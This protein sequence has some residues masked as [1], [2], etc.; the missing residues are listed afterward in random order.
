[1]AHRDVIHYELLQTTEL[2]L[3]ETHSCDEVVSRNDQDIVLE[4]AAEDNDEAKTDH[5]SVKSP[6][7]ICVWISTQPRLAFG[8]RFRCEL[9]RFY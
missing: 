6:L 4:T 7:R 5:S 1:M 3:L 9:V 8:K 2:G